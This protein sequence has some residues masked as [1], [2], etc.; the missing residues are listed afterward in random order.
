MLIRQLIAAALLFATPC[1]HAA[2]YCVGAETALH[3]ALYAAKHSPEDDEI[4]LLAGRIE[5]RQDLNSM[6]RIEGGLKLRGGYASGCQARPFNASRSTLSGNGHWLLLFLHSGDLLMERMDFT[7]FDEVLVIGNIFNQADGSIDIVRSAFRDGRNGLEI[8]A[9]GHDVRVS[10]SLFVGNAPDGTGDGG[11]GLRVFGYRNS[12]R[13]T[14]IFINNITA[15]NNAVGLYVEH[16]PDGAISA[17]RAEVV[18]MVGDE[19]AVADL[20]MASSI[21]LRSSMVATIDRMRGATLGMRSGGNLATDPQLDALS[22]PIA[23]GSPAINSGDNSVLPR[24][25]LFVMPLDYAGNPRL[26]GSAVDRGA[27]EVR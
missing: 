14:E 12:M 1:L 2:V 19:N 10:D 26:R 23:P 17:P 27:F 9:W 13:N 20:Q 8:Q 24:G 25:P 21:E 16:W 15:V 4:R 6:T 11:A 7:G 18:N 22:R 3:A 5:L